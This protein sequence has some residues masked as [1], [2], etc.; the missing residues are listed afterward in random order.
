M[1]A[2]LTRTE[3]D[4][5]FNVFV[6]AAHAKYGSHGYSTGYLQYLLVSLDAGAH[7]K[8]RLASDGAQ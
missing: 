7:A 6:Q 1:S 3:I 8:K 2:K 4:D 5:Q